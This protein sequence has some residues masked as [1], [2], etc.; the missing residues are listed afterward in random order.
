ME[1]LRPQLAKG[2]RAQI[3]MGKSC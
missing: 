2:F 1:S 3:G